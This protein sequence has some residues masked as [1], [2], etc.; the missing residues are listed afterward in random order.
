MSS[1]GLWPAADIDIYPVTCEA[2]SNGRSNLEVLRAVIAGGAKIIQLREKELSKRDYYNLALKFR[3]ITRQH[4]V[5]FII[6]DYV[7]VALAVEADGVH[8][9]QDDLPAAI[10]RKLAPGLLIGAS[11]HN[12]AEA[13]QAEEDGADY[14]NIG[15]IFKTKTKFMKPLGV[16]AIEP[17]ASKIKIPY[18]V[19]GGITLE[20]VDEVLA[21]GV[22]R[23]AVVTAITKAKDIQASTRMFINKIKIKKKIP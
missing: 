8:L 17:I 9:G 3:E 22:G 14:I 7:D 15:P 12:L 18:T 1:S 19:M 4:N 6:N 13:L 11:T 10:V 23:I 20:N 2:L 5:L 21:V 16:G